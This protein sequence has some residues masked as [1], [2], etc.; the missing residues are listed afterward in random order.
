MTY[1]GFHKN[2]NG[3]GLIAHIK[4]YWL[5]YLFVGNIVF[6]VSSTASRLGMLEVKASK[7]DDMHETLQ[8][9]LTDIKSRLASIDTSL[10]YLRQPNG[11]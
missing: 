1:T 8:I 3:S 5:I 10:Q 6:N 4:D 9:D 11:K 2:D 7:N